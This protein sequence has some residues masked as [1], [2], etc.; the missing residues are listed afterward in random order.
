MK[1]V[2]WSG[3]SSALTA[4]SATAALAAGL[5][6]SPLGLS[7]QESTPEAASASTIPP[8]VWQLAEFDDGA[9]NV[10]PVENSSRY[11]IQFAPSGFAAIGADCNRGMTSWELDEGALTFNEIATT[12]ALCPEDSLSDR[13]LGDLNQTTTA[14]ID[15]SGASDQLVLG[16][17]NGGSLRFDASLVG[18]LWQWEQFQG[19]DDTIV[20]PEDPSHY[21]LEFQADG[22]VSGQ[23]DCNRGMGSYTIGD[24]GVSFTILLAT[25]RMACPEGSLDA[26]FLRFVTESTSFVIRD[27]KLSLALP[28]DGGITTFA[29]VFDDPF[30]DDATP[31]SGA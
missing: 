7:A 30:V 20:A 12:L 8:I 4:L 11:T 26:D 6:A 29:P 31:E 21:A 14:S 18:V 19:G 9:G 25:T 17:E 2:R 10:T 15:Q 28:M 23:I 24:D 22:S 16:L 5:L 13:F 3:I 27:G 1:R